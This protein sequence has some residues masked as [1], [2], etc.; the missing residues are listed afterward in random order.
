MTSKITDNVGGLKVIVKSQNI[1]LVA[2]KEVS[3]KVI[4]RASRSKRK[5]KGVSVFISN[6]YYAQLP[7]PNPSSVEPVPIKVTEKETRNARRT[8][9]RE[10]AVG[11]GVKI[12]GNSVLPGQGSVQ[13]PITGVRTVARITIDGET[14]EFE[15]TKGTVGSR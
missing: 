13:L 1:N 7:P 12:T 10:F 14:K 5:R 9:L 2:Y 3:G 11:A 6:T 15:T 4:V 8:V